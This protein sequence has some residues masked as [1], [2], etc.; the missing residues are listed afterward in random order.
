M[1]RWGSDLR[2]KKKKYCLIVWKLR[3]L[4]CHHHDEELPPQ[5]AILMTHKSCHHHGLLCYTHEGEQLLS[6]FI[7]HTYADYHTLPCSWCTTAT[8]SVT[9]CTMPMTE[10]A[11]P[12]QWL[13]LPCSWQRNGTLTVTYFAMLMTA[14]SYPYRDLLCHA[15]DGKS[16][17]AFLASGQTGHRSQGKVSADPE[18]AQLCSV[19]LC[20]L[21]WNNH[22]I[23]ICMYSTLSQPWSEW[24][25]IFILILDNI[26]LHGIS[27]V[28][29]SS[30]QWICS[31]KPTCTKACLW[32][33]SPVP[34][35]W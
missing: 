11:W 9:D 27:S 29:F 34:W 17:S 19:H 25:F 8:T 21:P 10:Q 24:S 31:K 32:Q 4:Y 23:K 5:H 1:R 16:H 30:R 20:R 13:T 33:V 7:C 6:R 3:Y 15:H 28:Q 12:S 26:T 14:K 35:S 18:T 22:H 2:G